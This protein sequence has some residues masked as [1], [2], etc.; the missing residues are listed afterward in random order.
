MKAVY[1]PV[2]ATALLTS[3][4]PAGKA[5]DCSKATTATEL[6]ICRSTAARQAE[7]AMEKAYFSLRG[8]LADKQ[9]KWLLNSQRSWLQARKEQCLADAPCLARWARRHARELAAGLDGPAPYW[10]VQQG[11]RYHYAITISAPRF[12]TPGTPAQKAYNRWLDRLI[13]KAPA[14][15]QGEPVLTYGGEPYT[16]QISVELKRHDRQLLSA[17][18]DIYEYS[19]GAHPNSWTRAIN[20]QTGTGRKLDIAKLF[21]RRARQHL[22]HECAGQIVDKQDNVYGDRNRESAIKSLLLEDYPGV[23][24]KHVLNS[25]FWHFTG[26]QA[27]IRFDS[28]AIGPYAAGSFECTFAL[29]R[30]AEMTRFPALFSVH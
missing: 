17:L 25:S 15:R 27:T 26:G 19:G 28:Y 4:S 8:I 18:A 13:A 11:N 12:L 20:L 1:G 23:V 10:F 5:F 3:L 29:D 7:H 2:L 14:G 6:A 16:H 24:K 9:R 22:I 21:D 30:L